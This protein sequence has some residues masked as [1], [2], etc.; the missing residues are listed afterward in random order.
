VVRFGGE[1]R[2]SKKSEDAKPVVDGYQNYAV[3]D[4]RSVFVKSTRRGAAFVSAAVNP[5]HDGKWFGDGPLGN[6][7]VEEEAILLTGVGVAAV[8]VA[9][10][11]LRAGSAELR[12][13]QDPGPGLR[14]DRFAPAEIADGRLRIRD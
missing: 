5:E 7:D 6:D 9:E 14:G 2:V 1:F 11:G 4:E 8:P 12:S 13:V 10:I 3:I